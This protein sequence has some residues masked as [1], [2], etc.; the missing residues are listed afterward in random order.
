MVGFAFP[1]LVIAALLGMYSR[2][3]SQKAIAASV[4]KA[5]PICLSVDSARAGGEKQWSSGI[6]D[7]KTLQ[8]WG[9]E[10]KILST[11]PVVTAWAIAMDKVEEGRCEFRVPALNPRNP[12]SYLTPL[13]KK[14]LLALRNN[15]LEEYYLV[16][17]KTN[18]LHYFRPVRPAEDCLI[19]HGNPATSK[20]CPMQVLILAARLPS[21]RTDRRLPQN[22]W[23]KLR[24]G[25]LKSNQSQMTYLVLS[26][27]P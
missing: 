5:C 3:A 4:D 12:A 22:K 18:S 26:G 24:V 25:S 8:A 15:G 7:T 17:N 11:V 16:N 23:R 6:S 20:N 9:E 10:E 14:A 21:L 2:D 19:C 13:E 27:C 1:A